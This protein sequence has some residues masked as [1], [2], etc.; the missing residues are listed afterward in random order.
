MRPNSLPKLL[1]KNTSP[2]M[3]GSSDARN[4]PYC[5]SNHSR[6]SSG[7]SDNYSPL[8]PTSSLRDHSR[9]P[10]SSSS[11][12]TT[13]PMYEHPDSPT[14]AAKPALDDLV[15]DPTER[16][17]EFELCDVPHDS[18]CRCRSFSFALRK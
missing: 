4:S 14:S 5:A 10:S 9:F 17:D 15:E 12:A 8:T 18:P 13:P 2:K 16:E 3:A 1:V 6:E 11:L 7:A